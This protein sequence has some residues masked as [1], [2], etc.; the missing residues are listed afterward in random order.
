MR[1][2]L[3]GDLPGHVLL[4]P[5]ADTAMTPDEIEEAYAA[6]HDAEHQVDEV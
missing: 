3:P 4:A 5:A 2:P 6:Q 1:Q